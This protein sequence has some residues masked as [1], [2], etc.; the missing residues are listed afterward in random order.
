MI[1]CPS[2]KHQEFVGT[3]YCTECGTRLVSISPVPTVSISR[4]RMD[5]EANATKPA[6][7]EGPELESGAI[8]G[9][10]L[11]QAVIGELS[12]GKALNL[13]AEEIYK[14]FNDNGRKTG[15]LAKLPE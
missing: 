12:T 11:N 14:V 1:E 4:D 3:L 8:L 7:P 2:C 5:R 15:M 6:P 10:R 13:A 9:L